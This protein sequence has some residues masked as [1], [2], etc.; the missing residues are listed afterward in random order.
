M[1]NSKQFALAFMMY[2]QDYDETSPRAVNNALRV[3][4]AGGPGRLKGRTG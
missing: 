3:N 2:I 1:S 4:V